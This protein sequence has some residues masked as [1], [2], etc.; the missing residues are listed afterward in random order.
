[1]TNLS[2]S[3]KDDSFHQ[4]KKTMWT[5][6]HFKKT[7]IWL[8]RE[9][10]IITFHSLNLRHLSLSCQRTSLVRLSLSIT[11]DLF[12]VCRHSLLQTWDTL[13]I[14]ALILRRIEK[15]QILSCMKQRSSNRF[16]GTEVEGDCSV[17]DYSVFMWRSSSVDQHLKLHSK[18]YLHIYGQHFFY[19][20][21]FGVQTWSDSAFPFCTNINIYQK[22]HN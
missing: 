15:P 16:W 17:H 2:V 10:I 22:L 8:R 9:L 18:V 1:M 5:V 6:L 21:Q 7:W 19:Q 20:G 12:Q 13:H 14:T 3:Y 4:H 11:A